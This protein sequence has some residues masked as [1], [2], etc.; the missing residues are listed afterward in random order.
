MSDKRALQNW[1][2]IFAILVVTGLLTAVWPAV[3]GWFG[4]EG[5]SVS[6]E[7]EVQT[8]VINLPFPIAGA[9]VLELSSLAVVGILAVV[10]IGLVAGGGAVLAGAYT[11]LSRAAAD[12]KES[13]SFQESQSA[14][15]EIEKE[16]I[17]QLQEGR[18]V[19]ETDEEREGVWS[20]IS[21]TLI[22]LF[23]TTLAGNILTR[24][25]GVA[26]TGS[27]FGLTIAQSTLVIGGLDLLA[28]FVAAWLFRPQR[29]NKIDETDYGPIPWDS[30]WVIMTGLVVV[31]IGVGIVVYLNVPQ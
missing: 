20:A 23:F 30:L 11:L 7:A 25:L 31:G 21:T 28:V 19:D 24:A 29:I 6:F 26:G 5:A 27:L 4:G 8:V 1:I 16:R 12:V 3:T 18:Q 2:A 13:E 15:E 9:S 10:V 22:V 14:L 17:A